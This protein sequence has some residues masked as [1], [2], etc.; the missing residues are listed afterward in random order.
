M[1][2]RIAALLGALMLIVLGTV[3]LW[4]SPAAPNDEDPKLTINSEE[5]G[6]ADIGPPVAP[7]ADL[8]ADENP[9]SGRAED[10]VTHH[11][12]VQVLN[13]DK[14]AAV[15]NTKVF[16][17]TDAIRRQQIE[18][19]NFRTRDAW[20]KLHLLPSA[21]TDADGLVALKLPGRIAYL[22]AESEGTRGTMKIKLPK[23]AITEVDYRRVLSLQAMQE[24]EVKVSNYDGSALCGMVVEL[25]GVSSTAAKT[26]KNGIAKFSIPANLLASLA[27]ESFDGA[28]PSVKCQLP[29][30]DNP[31]NRV[32]QLDGKLRAAIDLPPSGSIEVRGLEDDGRQYQVAV[33]STYLKPGGRLSRKDTLHG[34]VWCSNFVPLNS[35]LTISLFVGEDNFFQTQEVLRDIPGPSAAGEN[36]VIDINES[37][38]RRVRGILLN[39]LGHGLASRGAR[40]RF[41]D[42][43]GRPVIESV[44]LT[45]SSDGEW[46]VYLQDGTDVLNQVEHIWIVAN[47]DYLFFKVTRKNDPDPNVSPYSYLFSKPKFTSSP[48][49]DLGPLAPQAKE[50]LVSGRVLNVE[51]EPI[52]TPTIRVVRGLP[53]EE[54]VDFYSSTNITIASENSA[55]SEVGEF[56]FHYTP[57]PFPSKCRLSVNAGEDFENKVIDFEPGTEGL[58]ILMHGNCNVE[59]S[60][61]GIPLTE[62]VDFHLIDPTSGASASSSS[63]WVGDFYGTDLSGLHQRSFYGVIPGTYTFRA[64]DLDGNLIKEIPNVIV[65]AGKKRFPLLRGIELGRNENIRIRLVIPEDGIP[66][67][68]LK[69][70]AVVYSSSE[71]GFQRQLGSIM[72][73][74]T[75]ILK[76]EYLRGGHILV[77]AGFQSVP[78][79]E[80]NDGDEIVLTKLPTIQLSIPR[81][82][83]ETRSHFFWLRFEKLSSD[84]PD[85]SQPINRGNFSALDVDSFAISIQS[86]G[87][88]IPI[89]MA[90]SNFEDAYWGTPIL[91]W[92]GQSMYLDPAQHT[93]AI[94][95]NIPAGFE[96]EIKNSMTTEDD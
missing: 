82:Y 2:L 62:R 66:P 8:V 64:L 93:E 5:V 22:F 1:N 28:M 52:D 69:D 78:L 30:L 54:D 29:L 19:N 61:K 45:T 60:F 49:Y 71:Q 72:L 34:A 57:T 84:L 70:K 37:G 47:L 40:V 59:F 32:Q 58:E 92:R 94:D 3:L 86:A 68:S 63:I 11:I 38:A 89:W 67:F 74:E 20:G 7:H 18:L 26:L 87:E 42:G 53:S 27:S 51:R 31:S 80:L 25:G 50:L 76:N 16:Y 36:I 9:G 21:M 35:K 73:D 77:V 10:V 79:N 75:V 88:Y 95:L 48:I 24:V 65:K 56:C 91:E 4:P 6:L 17:I 13:H 12:G 81:L 15:A 83:S 85:S 43:S 55:D 46:V 33:S 23:E 90:Y 41:L 44:L 14:W 96:A 39:S